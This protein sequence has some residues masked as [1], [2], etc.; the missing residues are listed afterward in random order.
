MSVTLV[1]VK[2][3]LTPT[4]ELFI[5]GEYLGLSVLVELLL[6]EAVM[7]QIK[8]FNLFI[9]GLVSFCF[10]VGESISLYWVGEVNLYPERFI[11]QTS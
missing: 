6:T 8:P 1:V 11:A 10:E 5:T 4:L 3:P 2:T 9:K 7:K